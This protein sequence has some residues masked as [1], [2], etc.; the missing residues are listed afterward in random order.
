MAISPISDHDHDDSRGQA[1]L[2]LKCSSAPIAKVSLVDDQGHS[3]QVDQ[4]VV[5]DDES[6]DE[7][8]L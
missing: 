2:R 5:H 6:P 3:I 7:F 1:H 8:H 4:N